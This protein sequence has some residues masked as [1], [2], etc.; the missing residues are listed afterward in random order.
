MANFRLETVR[1]SRTGLYFS[2]LY[3]PNDAEKPFAS[4]QPIYG[5]HED[6]MSDSVRMLKVVFDKEA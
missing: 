5:S 4:S 2:E 3:Y 6:A 1:D